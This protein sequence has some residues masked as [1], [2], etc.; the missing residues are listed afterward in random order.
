[1]LISV[2]ERTREMGILLAIGWSKGK[3]ICTI[4]GE[5]L[6]M[7]ILGAIIGNALG[8]GV[9]WMFHI[10]GMSGLEWAPSSLQL[11]VVTKSLFLASGLALLSAFYPAYVAS[12]LSPAQAIRYE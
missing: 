8:W 11:K 2:T 9:L 7:C 5:A 6:L 4:V 10:S 3:L 1:M 12:N